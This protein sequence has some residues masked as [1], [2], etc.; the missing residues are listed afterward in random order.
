MDDQSEVVTQTPSQTSTMNPDPAAATAVETN[1]ETKTQEA[2]R[3]AVV[4]MISSISADSLLRIYAVLGRPAGGNVAV[5]ISSGEPGGNHYLHPELIA[6]LVNEV[7]GTIIE[8]NTAYNGGRSDTASHLRTM[9]D[10]GFTAIAPVD[11][12]DAEGTISLPI[13]GGRHLTEVPVGSHFL[14]YGFVV[15]LAHFRGHS[16]AG[17]GGVIKNM[18]LGI[19]SREGKF[20]IHTAGASSTSF[21]G[22]SQDDFLESMSEAAKGMAD[23]MNGNMVYIN[24]MKDLSVD[25]DCDSSPAP[26]TMGNIGIL[27]SLDPVAVDQACVDLGIC[28]IGRAET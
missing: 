19:A 14:N 18:A 5:K 10:H 8:C 24:V 20:L 17:F 15:N 4:Y 23:H 16:V 3:K 7:K 2:P 9:E 25:C 12:M 6:Q 11:I 13:L 27:A 26:P 1:Q 22:G 21:W 28:R